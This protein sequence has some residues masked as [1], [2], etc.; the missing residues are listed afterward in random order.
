[1]RIA[2]IKTFIAKFKTEGADRTTAKVNNLVNAQN[3]VTTSGANMTKQQTRQARAGESA[4]RSF[5]AQAQG[6][7]GLVAAYAGAAATAYALQAAFEALSNAA[8]FEQTLAG[9]NTLS[10]AVGESGSQVLETVRSITKEQLTIAESASQANLALS[11]G[12]SLDQ[13]EGLTTVS[14]K[15]SRALGRDLTDA[16]NRVVRG[17]AKMEA[18]LLDELGIYTKIG[19]ATRAYA[20]AIGKSVSELTEYERRQAFVNGVIEE[21]NRKFKEIGTTIPTASEKLAAFGTKLLDV[22]T[23]VGSILAN[24]LA[25][26]ADFLTNNLAGSLSAVG[27]VMSLVAGKAVQE[28][29]GGF[30]KLSS[31]IDNFAGNTEK[32]LL[33]FSKSARQNSAVAQKAFASLGT[34]DTG[35]TKG[36][37]KDM[38][39][40]FNIFK[41]AAKEGTL[42]ST[43]SAAAN[44]LLTQRL[45]NLNTTRQKEINS[46]NSAS[47]AR[48]KARKELASL[49]SSRSRDRAAI[50]RQREAIDKATASINRY[51]N[52][53]HNTVL[54]IKATENAQK[55]FVA[56]TT[57]IAASVSRWAGGLVSGIGKAITDVGH[58]ASKA[59]S[60]AST[61][62]VIA[63]VAVGIGSS[64]AS[65]IGKQEEFNAFIGVGVQ[66]IQKLFEPGDYQ[67]TNKALTGMTSGALASL[68]KT[69]NALKDLDKFTFK[70]KVLGVELEITKSKE[71]L[72]REVSDILSTVI[73]GR[74]LGQ[75]FA[76][77]DTYLDSWVTTAA[78][79]V[80]TVLGLAI[81]TVLSP[82]A[83]TAA[84]A[85]YGTAAGAAIGAT[86][87]SY[88]KKSEALKEIGESAKKDIESKFG[89]GI[90]QGDDG[91]KMAQA[92]ALL[93]KQSGA[94]KNLSLDA[95]KYYDTQQAIIVSLKG[96]LNNLVKL[97]EVSD[98]LG[99]DVNSLLKDYSA[100][101]DEF[102]NLVLKP[103]LDIPSSIGIEIVI[104]NESEI[105]SSLASFRDV[106][107]SDR[108]S[109]NWLR[110]FFGATES[111]E[112]RNARQALAA[113]RSRE[114]YITN[115]TSDE[116]KND[117]ATRI[118]QEE[119]RI[120]SILTG[121]DIDK[122]N[123]FDINR[124]EAGVIN[125]TS[126]TNEFGMSVLR[127]QTSLNSMNDLII[128]GGASLEQLSQTEGTQRRTMDSAA[129]SLLAAQRDLSS[130]EAELSKLRNSSID[131]ESLQN[132]I[133]LVN[134]LRD[135][136]DTAENNYNIAKD[137]VKA[138]YDMISPIKTQLEV[139]KQMADILGKYSKER[140]H[141]VDVLSAE[142]VILTTSE[143][144][145]A[146]T[147]RYTNKIVESTSTSY[148]AQKNQLAT[149][150]AIGKETK[151]SASQVTALANANADN[152]KEV[153][154]SLA[155][156]EEQAR[157]V[158]AL[159]FISKEQA[160]EA[161]T[162]RQSIIAQ[163]NL[164]IEAAQTIK[165]ELISLQ[166][167]AKKAVTESQAEIKKIGQ[168]SIVTAIEFEIDRLATQQKINTIMQQFKLDKLQLEIELVQ[169]KVSSGTLSNIEGATQENTLQKQVLEERRNLINLEYQQATDNILAQI[170]LVETERD[171]KIGNIKAEAEVKQKS[172]DAEIALLDG[173]VSAREAYLNKS[174][175]AAENQI[176]GLV[177]AGNAIGAA[178][179]KAL[180]EGA[181][182]VAVAEG[183]DPGSIPTG[184][185]QGESM[186]GL[187][188]RLDTDISLSMINTSAEIMSAQAE[189]SKLTDAQINQTRSV[190]T[191]KIQALIDEWLITKQNHANKVELLEIEKQIE[192]EQAKQRIKDAKAGGAELTPLQEKLKELFDSI[193]GHIES[194]FMGLNDLVVY[195][196]GSFREVIGSLFKGIQQDVFRQ[197]IAEPLSTMLT[198]NLFSFGGVEMKGA[199][200]ASLVPTAGGKALLVSVVKG[201]MD[202][203]GAIDSSQKAAAQETTN[204]IGTFFGKE[205]AIAKFFGNLFG[206]GGILRNLLSGFG[207][208]VGSIFRGILSIFGVG[209]ASGGAVQQFASG[210]G[211]QKLAAGGVSLRDRV[212]A[213]LEPG[214]FVIRKPAARKIG[215][216]ALHQLNATGQ[217]GAASGNIQVNVK[218]E[219]SPKEA[220]TAQP[221]FDGEKYIIDVITRDL[222][223]NGPIRRSLR[224][225]R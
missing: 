141:L 74:T 8:R 137:S 134:S 176:I 184:A 79:G 170:K 145:F 97:Q 7:G 17:S 201:P 54:A 115:K 196:E 164:I 165:S 27:L 224:G 161:E 116:V 211:V 14:L 21:G 191:G 199:D 218:N 219:G 188:N 209:F 121:I 212:P 75:G 187:F 2:V 185:Y 89:A 114:S 122:L 167:E 155:L 73:E 15:A 125:A 87:T 49:E 108:A 117:I 213:L 31:I 10:T 180:T 13:I 130:A 82:G 25:P 178:I 44:K 52:S 59:V 77:L 225:N 204:T 20:A 60:A 55:A 32:K 118:Q 90:F 91:T 208:I 186:E 40:D 182:A 24:M 9:L 146:N 126:A 100:I 149:I 29:S 22:G 23:K 51:R 159:V 68:E 109:P 152:K 18:E 133:I 151:L 19:P 193:R 179:Y 156:T 132:Q 127:L 94:Q 102:E 33:A 148:Q 202:Y 48:Q 3:N 11:A 158:G 101:S 5:S 30:D 110:S 35:L 107:T 207:N 150:T 104:L 166:K 210:G 168:E 195:G 99:T 70:K 112:L 138:Y 160:Y 131:N 169:A 96:Q 154:Q 189:L 16:M 192:N 171:I 34:K 205:G 200:N 128:S 37:Y 38:K 190:A 62:T 175:E 203:F 162:A 177:N 223:N 147:L 67:K 36:I 222:S 65:L 111:V 119:Q 42:T 83:G 174:Q 69:D 57:G 135:Q 80:G 56:S 95:R 50:L 26:L 106:L 153:M 4:A 214:E 173:W 215:A 123:G 28:L 64:I 120:A 181:K 58:F 43:Q 113:Q 39:E 76:E 136:L 221:K 71:D 63:S 197:T 129:A 45:E 216:P 140:S 172:L 139:Q 194:A 47:A 72:V 41:K 157:A 53:L 78:T 6:L 98:T 183:L 92:F 88:L 46:I 143:E 144:K 93:E 217:M 105:L 12:F 66:L 163:I 84:G 124:Y 142:G 61:F 81:G 220:T 85:L 86:L 103:K 206:E 1:M 198:K